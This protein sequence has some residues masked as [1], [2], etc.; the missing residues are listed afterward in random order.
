MLSKSCPKES[1]IDSQPKRPRSQSSQVGLADAIHS[2]VGRERLTFRQMQHRI[3]MS[4]GNSRQAGLKVAILLEN[5]QPRA[6]AA[7]SLLA[8]NKE[9]WDEQDRQWSKR[10]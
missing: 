3:R 5:R 2:K 10:N 8:S 9:T 4:V 6:C 7:I 1:G